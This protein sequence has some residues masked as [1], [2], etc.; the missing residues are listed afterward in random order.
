MYACMYVHTPLIMWRS[1]DNWKE[2]A[3]L[4]QLCRSLGTKVP[5]PSKR[6]YPLSTCT[7]EHLYPQA[8]SVLR[9]HG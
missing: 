3:L 7:P 8:I 4:Y 6:L 1:E 2:L 9:A 5:V